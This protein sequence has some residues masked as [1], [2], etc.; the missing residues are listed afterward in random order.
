MTLE[1]LMK[2]VLT[3][4]G[5]AER[6][7][8]IQAAHFLTV[9][10][11]RSEN[12]PDK[13]AAFP[14]RFD[15][16]VEAGTGVGKTLAYLIPALGARFGLLDETVWLDPDH[17]RLIPR[18]FD[19]DR[20]TALG[21]I[22]ENETPSAVR[23]RIFQP[24]QI[25]VFTATK[26]LQDQ[27]LNHEL[28]R[29]QRIFQER[30][31]VHFT[32]AKLVGRKNY[33]C[34]ARMRRFVE[35]ARKTPQLFAELD[36]LRRTLET[37]LAQ[38]DTQTLEEAEAHLRSRNLKQEAA[39]LKDLADDDQAP[40]F[41]PSSSSDCGGKP[42]CQKCRYHQEIKQS[43]IADVVVGNHYVFAYRFLFP[44][45][46]DPEKPA[47]TDSEDSARRLQALRAFQ[48]DMMESLV[49]FDEAHYLEKA[50]ARLFTREISLKQLAADAETLEKRLDALSGSYASSLKHLAAA[51]PEIAEARQRFLETMTLF[52]AELRG[53]RHDDW[54]NWLK[55]VRGEIP[56][57]LPVWETFCSCLGDRLDELVRLSNELKVAWHE[58]QRQIRTKTTASLSVLERQ[59]ELFFEH[60]P[61]WRRLQRSL[62]YWSA[63][64]RLTNAPDKQTENYAVD[65]SATRLALVPIRVAHVLQQSSRWQQLPKSFVSATLSDGRR[66]QPFRFF[67]KSLGLDENRVLSVRLAS[68]F[69]YAE[70][71][72]LYVPQD[73]PDPSADEEA[74][75]IWML[76]EA[77]RLVRLTRGGALILASSWK[78]LEI[79]AE[80]LKKTLG[81]SL[82]ILVQGERTSASIR[83]EFLRSDRVVA[84]GTETF[85]QGFDVPGLNLRQVIITRLPFMPPDDPIVRKLIENE[86]RRLQARS[87]VASALLDDEKISL[88]IFSE[89]QLPRAVLL[90]K[91][92]FGRLIRTEQDRGVVSVLDPRILTRRYG[93]R[94][95]D[96]LPG[97]LPL[98]V[99]FEELKQD[100]QRLFPTLSKTRRMTGR[101]EPWEKS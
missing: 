1:E 25:F 77:E 75:K 13:N 54:Q 64:Q 98:A 18:M 12:P 86:R 66:H 44:L 97:E 50:I 100:V 23:M 56:E 80:H 94:F 37:I 2:I 51:Q 88:K 79:L 72:V 73:A 21:R 52:T 82:P 99:S 30:F 29:L 71:A 61:A 5:Y 42:E 38:P 46:R 76:E 28:P 63:I 45:M 4:L 84:I 41:P 49:I 59:I 32:Y 67:V 89:F 31:N 34:R 16:A 57:K 6:R 90:F 83:Q 78:D 26:M 19:L 3:D 33:L 27:I 92:G 85:W 15:S 60:T 47:R 22:P 96:V 74:W 40:I 36:T 101:L 65:F 10:C 14:L 58:I 91:Q 95:L 8:Q 20:E 69:P 43:A 17:P 53:L 68:P 87:G 9:P 93:Q 11:C 24:R 48:E 55:I 62:Q 39:A 35:E 7:E 70:C 81:K